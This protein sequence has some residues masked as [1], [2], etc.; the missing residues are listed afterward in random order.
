MTKFQ[1]LVILCEM[2]L[3]SSNFAYTI[4]TPL[5]PPMFELLTNLRLECFSRSALKT[6]AFLI[7]QSVR[8]EVGIHL[9]NGEEF[10]IY[11]D[12]N[13]FKKNI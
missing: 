3:T 4:F 6:D 8:K 10:G 12:I 9:T 7:N 1:N 11:C 2:H 13:I 5:L